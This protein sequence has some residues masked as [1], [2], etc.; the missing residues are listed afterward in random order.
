[1]SWRR[2][3]FPARGI[4]LL[5]L[6]LYGRVYRYASEA[7][8]ILD[9]DGTEYRYSAG[10]A[11]F[12]SGAAPESMAVSLDTD[13]DWETLWADGQEVENQPATLRRILDGMI[14]ERAR[15]LVAGVVTAASFG[16]PGSPGVLTFTVARREG[17]A[18]DL[19][20][21]ASEVLN[22]ENW[23]PTLTLDAQAVGAHYPIVFGYPGHPG[24]GHPA[25]P[26]LVTKA[27]ASTPQA[28][29]GQ[30]SMQATAADMWDASDGLQEINNRALT[31]GNDGTGNRVKTC[32]LA[33]FSVTPILG[34][35]Y[36][37]SFNKSDGGGV[38][39]AEGGLCRGAGDVILWVLDHY[40]GDAKVDRQRIYQ[41]KGRLNA[42]KIDGVINAPIRAWDWIRSALL[43]LLPA[44]IR[45]GPDGRYIQLRTL[46]ATPLDS[47]AILVEGRDIAR[48]S[49]PQARSA[50]LNDFTISYGPDLGGSRM[51]FTHR[52][53]GDQ[54]ILASSNVQQ[55][56]IC[57]DSRLRYGSA[58]GRRISTKILWDEATALRVLD[59]Q[60][61]QFALPW[62]R[63][64]YIAPREAEW[65]SEGAVV[66]ITDRSFVERLAVVVGVVVGDTDVTVVV[67]YFPKLLTAQPALEVTALAAPVNTV[68]PVI[69]GD[70]DEDDV[71]TCVVGTWTGE[72]A[73]VFSFQWENEGTPISGATSI[74]YTIQASDAG[75]DLTCDVTG[76]NASGSATATSNT[77]TANSVLTFLKPQRAGADPTS[78]NAALQDSGG[79]LTDSGSALYAYN[80]DNA[81]DD[82]SIDT[83]GADGTTIVATD[84]VGTPFLWD[85]INEKAFG[86]VVGLPGTDRDTDATAAEL[87]ATSASDYVDSVDIETPGYVAFAFDVN[88]RLTGTVER[89]MDRPASSGTGFLVQGASSN[90]GEVRA[91]LYDGGSNSADIRLSG[92]FAT[93][94][95]VDI[96]VI[97][98]YDGTTL[99]FR[100]YTAAGSLIDGG[101]DTH[102]ASLTYGAHF[103]GIANDLSKPIRG[104]LLR[105]RAWTSALSDSEM[106]DI[107]DG[108]TSSGWALD[109]RGLRTGVYDSAA[110]T[111]LIYTLGAG[112]A[113]TAENV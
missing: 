100:A 63:V 65:L 7:V 47:E 46:T 8:T 13:E 105:S 27:I 76:T 58:A 30:H 33:G 12:S 86:T 24:G 72:E 102:S 91:I 107:A 31:A 84:A 20:P 25:W 51:L 62:M 28:I 73:P 5:D 81:S 39:N 16:F 101:T 92:L 59:D 37:A 4:W 83:K 87:N 93:Y 88:L 70:L 77:L 41:Q 89:I 14:L 35:K 64:E 17:T 48:V 6:E 43:P 90:S 3:E 2:D 23:P 18:G 19:M 104:N 111:N 66:T 78:T 57:V 97:V 112:T 21:R 45:E 103:L 9:K 50:I 15:T 109:A 11:D 113:V 69:S 44:D 74:T 79:Q 55:S 61:A 34:R 60:A 95:D 26:V 1:M 67:D 10:L 29:V 68:A 106:D 99:R 54:T 80:G 42:Y 94:E 71:L 49:A 38:L 110:D 75:D 96:Q 56:R 52:L 53:T 32:S 36:Y 22:A 108:T 40:G 85:R 98:S 82:L